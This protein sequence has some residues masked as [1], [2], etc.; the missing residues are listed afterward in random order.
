MPHRD[1]YSGTRLAQTPGDAAALN[2]TARAPMGQANSAA[3]LMTSSRKAGAEHGNDARLAPPG[4]SQLARFPRDFGQR[5]LL[6]IDTEEEFN[7]N[8]PFQRTG[9]GLDHIGELTRFQSFCEQI[10]ARPVYLVDWPVVED[11]RAVE[12]IG[13]AAAR[14]AAEVGVQLHPWVNP[15][16]DERLS[17]ANSFAGNLPPDLEAAKLTRLRDKVA[18]AFGKQPVIYR[19]GRYGIGEATPAILRDTGFAIDTSVRPLFDYSQASG[20]DFSAFPAQPYWLDEQARVL[21]LPITSV[22]WGILRRYGRQLHRL[23]RHV[24]TFF[25]AFSRLRLLE[26]IALTPEGVT[27]QEAIRGIDIA[28]DEGLPLLVL[29]L[30]SPSLAPGFTP[31]ATDRAGVE[32]I[33]SWLTI[34]FEYLHTFGVT[35][36]GI[37]E[38]RAAAVKMRDQ[39]RNERL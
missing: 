27:P 17:E 32:A 37:D 22:Y 38:V 16:F 11:A 1:P 9:H 20:P 19:A 15:P 10:G 25:A 23:Q 33:Y 35:S 7:W 8:A 21:E 31:Y 24:P 12:I 36:V 3:R 39:S 29:S 30:H 14:G 26:R 18:S 4:S 5:V 34:V 28:L 6:T 13:A 2:G